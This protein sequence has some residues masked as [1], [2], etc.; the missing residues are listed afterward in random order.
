M[1]ASFDSTDR[2]GA[3]RED[4]SARSPRTTSIAARARASRW[5][6][7]VP[8]GHH[9]E[10]AKVMVSRPHARGTRQSVALW[11]DPLSRRVT[12]SEGATDVKA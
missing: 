2:S 10:V 5:R 3:A 11:C 8:T 1:K 9:E 7:M 12:N 6:N 4:R